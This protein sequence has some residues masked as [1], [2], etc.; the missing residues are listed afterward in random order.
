MLFRQLFD[1]ETS[2]YTYLLADEETR[3]AVII[4][5]VRDQ[6][7]R[8]TALVKELGLRVIY[9]LETH[10]HADHITGAGALRSR[11]GCKTV[12]SK[13][14]GAACD[15]TIV[16][17]DVIRFGK[18]VIEA[19]A[20]PGHTAGCMTYVVPGHNMA[21]TGDALLI[22]G[23]GRTDFQH[24]DSRKLYRSVH[25]KI[26]SL[27]DSTFLYP[28]HDYKGRMVTTV[29]EEKAFN[30]RLGDAVS[31][32]QFVGIM[33]QLHL[34][35]PK[36]I[37]EAVSANLQCGISADDSVSGEAAPERAWAPVVRSVMGVAELTPEWLA[38]HA[39][40]V[41]IVDVREPDEFN[42]EFGHIAGAELVPLNTVGG[43][44]RKWNHEEPIVTVCRSGG[45]SGKAAVEL[46]RMGFKR[47]ASMKGGMSVW[48]HLKLP[49]VRQ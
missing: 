15:V 43:V 1:P 28:G 10:I 6:V 22:R 26:F 27:P 5:S 34:A 25:D 29:A 17:G 45:R 38:E 2:T 14:G 41:R 36:K 18:H 3:E 37:D 7:E 49:A 24:G 11:L 20:T 40:E 33:S 35:K 4:D 44:A 23:S 48:N 30:P 9:C 32:D 31:E 12:V 47:V 42:A 13:N 39:G 21:F 46:E 19:R 8:D 16:D